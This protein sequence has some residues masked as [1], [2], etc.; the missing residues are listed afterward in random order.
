M[1]ITSLMPAKVL[2]QDRYLDV[3]S[4]KVLQTDMD[5]R[6][7]APVEDQNGEKCALIKVTSNVKGLV[8]ESP[9]MGIV[10]Q[11]VVRGEIWVYIPAESRAVT[12]THNDFPPFRGYQ[13]PVRI[14]SATVYEM[15]INGHREDDGKVS[16]NAQML[17]LN[18]NPASASLYIDDEEMP[19]ENGLFTAMMP[20]GTHTYRIEAKDYEPTSGTIDL[21]DQQWVRSIRLKEK[22]GYLNVTSYPEDSANVY[23]NDKLVGIT[24]YKSSNLEPMNYKV[25]IEKALYFT[26]DTVATVNTGG[27]TTDMVVRMVSTIKPKEGRKTFILGD[28]AF[29][30]GGQTSFGVMVG[31]AAES[32]AYIHARTDFNSVD[33]SRECDDNGVVSEDNDQPYF[34][35][36][37][38]SKTSRLSVTGGYIHRFTLNNPFKYGGMG[39]LYGYIGAGYGQR[40]LAWE[41]SDNGI[42]TD[43]EWIKNTDHSASGIAAEVGGICR[44]GSFAVS[45]GYQTVSFKY[46]EFSLGVGFFF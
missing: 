36:N 8:F 23:I 24:P 7:Q 25:R 33:T 39:G 12:I 30:G 5:A 17:T 31:M 26:K 34:S 40:T 3:E 46:H 20:K 32:G 14:E 11:E 27:E 38:N 2:A 22:F 10:K 4:F 28:M 41:T 43:T 16:T 35:K 15:K 45:L 44:M 6:I 18:V 1:V 37:K 29:G 21:A 42:T 13:Y 19:T 9:A